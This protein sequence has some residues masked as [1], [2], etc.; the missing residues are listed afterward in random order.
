MSATI[1]VVSKACGLGAILS[2]WMY[3]IG[4]IYRSLYQ[5]GVPDR[6]GS[7]DVKVYRRLSSGLVGVKVGVGIN[8]VAHGAKHRYGSELPPSDLH[9]LL[10]VRNGT[11]RTFGRGC[12]IL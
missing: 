11:Q 2:R 4:E 12:R 8:T 10:T 9:G 3:R 6:H 7:L 5:G 1:R